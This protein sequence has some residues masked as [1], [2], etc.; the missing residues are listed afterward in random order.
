MKIWSTALIT[1]AVSGIA[2]AA[3]INFRPLPIINLNEAGGLS[4]SNISFAESDLGFMN[5]D[6]FNLAAGFVYKINAITVFSV[7]SVLGDPL[8]NE[9]SSVALWGR[10]PGQALQQLAAGTPG[11]TFNGQFV[12]N[13]NPDIS[14]T[15]I[16]YINGEDFEGVGS[17][18]VFY[19]IW[20]TT[21]SNLNWIVLG[22]TDYEYAVRGIG[23]APDAQTFYGYWFSHASNAF[24]GGNLQFDGDLRFRVFDASNP[25]A[26]SALVNPFT[27]GLWDKGADLNLLMDVDVYGQIPEP[28][29]WAMMGIGLAGAFFAS[30]R[31]KQ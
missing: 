20:A 22:G 1:L 9:F 7:A 27:A 10:T 31:R 24:V 15:L 23:V 6:D 18:G 28:S 16:N 11:T 4:R 30:R 26:A 14:H 2:P 17:Q 13:S 21:F 19:P 3:V 25:N 12:G 29:T 8:G 5:G